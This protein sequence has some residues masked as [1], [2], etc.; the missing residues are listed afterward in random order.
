M[1]Y[2]S[3][4]YTRYLLAIAIVFLLATCKDDEVEPSNTT[5]TTEENEYVNN[6]ILENMKFW[7]LWNDKIPANPDQTKAPADFFESLLYT[8][9]DRF[10]WIQENYQELLNSL[11]GVSKEGGYEYRLYRESS[12]NSNVIAQIVYIKPSS[13]AEQAGLKRGD[14]ITHINDQQ[15]T[16]SNYQ[17]LIGSIGANHTL[18]Y[19]PLLIE[20]EKFDTEK[21]ASITTVEYQEDPNYMHTVIESGDHKIGYFVYNFFAVGPTSTSTTYDDEMESVFADFKSQGITDLVLDLRYNSGGSETSANNLASLI[22]TGVTSSNVFL[23][24]EYNEDVENEIINDASMGEAYLTSNFKTKA[25]N[26]GSQLQNSRLY[27]LASSRTASASELV[28][29]ALKPY[30]DVFIV[31]DTTYGKNV[32]SISL[33][34]ENDSK[35][36]WGMQPIVVKVYNSLNQSDYSKGFVPNIL[37]VDN[38]LYIYPLGDTRENLLS[39]ALQQITGQATGGRLANREKKQFIGSS[40]DEKARGFTLNVD[41]VDI[42][43]VIVH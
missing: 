5:A 35:N 42:K 23:K 38:S 15:M 21:T 13:P 7:Y 31:G 33:Y 29:N 41:Q 27:V 8:S 3:S 14:V 39:L 22:G 37:N 25:S 10:S 11:Q 26:V 12:S 20:E 30:M 28:I 18:R 2:I 1:R 17:T 4:S 36:T 43:K 32:G 16:L 19:R 24:R 40:L 6:W 34:K 9:E